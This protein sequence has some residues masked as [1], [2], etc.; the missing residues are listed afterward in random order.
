M[1]GRLGGGDRRPECLRQQ[2]CAVARKV[3]QSRRRM[4]CYPSCGTD[5]GHTVF[6]HATRPVLICAAVPP[7]V[8]S[9]PRDLQTRL[10]RF[11]EELCR[12]HPGVLLVY[13]SGSDVLCWGLRTWAP[14]GQHSS[15]RSLR[16]AATS[17]L[18]VN[19]SSVAGSPV[20]RYRARS[21]VAALHSLAV[22]RMSTTSTLP[23][24]IGI[25]SLRR[26]K[27]GLAP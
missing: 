12:L 1:R 16:H 23:V 6:P 25:P 14:P 17:S 11:C 21:S 9:S 7:L 3:S 10:P 15:L 2:P 22:I 26:L 24:P 13:S 27:G 18:A 8:G 19:S 5:C 20:S 4:A